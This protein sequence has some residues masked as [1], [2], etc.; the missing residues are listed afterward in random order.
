MSATNREGF[1][2][3]AHVMGFVKMK[4]MKNI[5]SLILSILSKAIRAKF[6]GECQNTTSEG[7]LSMIIHVKE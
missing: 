4:K 2:G 3:V 5:A 6:E 1:V 7:C